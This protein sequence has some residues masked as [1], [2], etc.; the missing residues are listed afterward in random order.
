MRGDAD[1]QRGRPVPT[2]ARGSAG[3]PGG[4]LPLR[5]VG[6]VGGFVLAVVATAVVFLTD[7]P[8][9]LRLAVVG[10][11]WAFVLALL[12]TRRAAPPAD[13]A[14]AGNEA[15]LRRAY[16]AE[17]AREVAARREYEL[18]LENRLR[19]EAEEAMR[20]ELDGLRRDLSTLSALRQDVAALAELRRDV[21]G[22][23]GLRQEVAA[24]SALR[25]EIAGPGGLRDEVRALSEVREEVRA[26]AAVRAELLALP[27]LRAEMGRL[28][29]ELA[30]Q[31]SSEMLVERIVMRTQSTRQAAGETGELR[32]VESSAAW[33]DQPPR[34]LTGGWPAVSLDARTDDR[35]RETRTFEAVTRTS[36]PVEPAQAEPAQPEPRHGRHERPA[37]PPPSPLDWLA[38]RS[39]TDDAAGDGGPRR[40][41]TDEA[42]E[43]LTVER[44]VPH[45]RERTAVPE[46][47]PTP[48]AAPPPVAG[49]TTAPTTSPQPVAAP[50]TTQASALPTPGEARLAQILAESRVSPPSGGRRRRRYRDDED[51][52]DD[53][54]ARVLKGN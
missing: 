53:V 14:A 43:G 23:G 52:A 47:W 54:L 35:P 20:A 34:E 7:N 6:L 51:E 46:A 27:E 45:R 1:Q 18:E 19:R 9:V 40:R 38:S 31:L 29:T 22:P 33:A 26:L 12:A 36:R 8:Q 32:T 2:A 5:T 41:H 3:R 4:G 10:G 49:P 39:L 24:L 50:Q 21:T 25:Q 11:A 42:A 13:G 17:L 44:P 37:D 30:E 48:P 15:D 16:E 28:R